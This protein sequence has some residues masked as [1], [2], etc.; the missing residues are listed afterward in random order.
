MFPIYWLAFRNVVKANRYNGNSMRFATLHNER[1]FHY[2]SIVWYDFI[3]Y[4]DAFV[5]VYSFDK[6]ICCRRTKL[7][8]NF[9]F[10][11]YKKINRL[12][13]QR[14]QI[15]ISDGQTMKS[16]CYCKLAWNEKLKKYIKDSAGN[17]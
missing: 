13:D 1:C 10:L 5:F 9:K 7:S 4:T 17:A 3:Y 2:N 16:S 8:E 14:K 15:I 11:K 12:W 6:E